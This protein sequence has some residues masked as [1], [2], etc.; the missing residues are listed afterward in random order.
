[1]IKN[2]FLPQQKQRIS[3]KRYQ[4]VRVPKDPCPEDHMTPTVHSMDPLLHKE[5]Y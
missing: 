2:L 4:A 5:L 3:A 1:M